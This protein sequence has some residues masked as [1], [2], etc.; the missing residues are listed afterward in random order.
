MHELK[1]LI[2]WPSPKYLCLYLQDP[3]KYDDWRH[4]RYPHLAEVLQQFPSCKPQ[5]S[6]LAVLLPPLQ[7]RFYSISSSPLAHKQS[8]H[9]TVAV[10]TYKTQSKYNIVKYIK[11]KQ[12][13]FWKHRENNDFVFFRRTGTDPLWRGIDIFRI[14]KTWWWCFSF[15]SKVT[16][17]I[18]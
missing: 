4:F 6:L 10:V 13:Y 18:V 11:L 8:I 16:T 2:K 15:H 7:P 12:K 17:K 14:F 5:A 3:N 1:F 9:L